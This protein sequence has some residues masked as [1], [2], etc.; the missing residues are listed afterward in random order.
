MRAR[1]LYTQVI[2]TAGKTECQR[3][4][5]TTE[6]EIRIAMAG[7]AAEYIYCHP[8]T[9]GFTLADCNAS[10]TDLADI[11]RNCDSYLPGQRQQQRQGHWAS[12]CQML[13][14]KWSV[15]QRVAS[16]IIDEP[17][18][19]GTVVEALLAAAREPM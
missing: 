12:I 9:C 3:S 14:S 13:T 5:L 10:N 11:D 15:V 1:L 8:D 4:T 19:P 17:Y 18:V 2:G 7:P 16:K 6:R